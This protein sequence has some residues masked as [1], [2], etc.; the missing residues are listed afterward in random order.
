VLNIQLPIEHNNVYVTGPC[1]YKLETRDELEQ[2]DENELK[3]F[4]CPNEG[5]LL[6]V[7]KLFL[8]GEAVIPDDH[9][10]K[11]ECGE[12]KGERNRQYRAS[13]RT[14]HLPCL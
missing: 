6:T 14:Y 10:K 5:A 13:I 12:E 2:M 11:V 7:A 1:R 8:R 3:R 9:E 4:C